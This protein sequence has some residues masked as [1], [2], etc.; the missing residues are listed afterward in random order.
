MAESL[1]NQEEP[2]WFTE[3]TL[4]QLAGIADS[5]PEKFDEHYAKLDIRRKLQLRRYFFQRL[6][7]GSA[8]PA[9]VASRSSDNGDTDTA[10][11]SNDPIAN[12]VKSA[13]IDIAVPGAG[14]RHGAPAWM[15]SVDKE[16]AKPEPKA[17][18]EEPEAPQDDE[19]IAL[20]ASPDLGD[21][22][23]ALDALAAD[24]TEADDPLSAL[25]ALTADEPQAE[26]TSDELSLDALMGGETATKAPAPASKDAMSL[27]DLFAMGDEDTA[28]ATA[29]ASDDGSMSLDD[30]F[31]DDGGVAT[32]TDD[33]EMSLDDLFAASMEEASAPEETPA[34]EKP[35]AVSNYAIPTPVEMSNDEIA[36]ILRP[37]D[38]FNGINDD[39]LHT[40]AGKMDAIQFV[41][42]D[43]LCNEGDIGEVMWVIVEGGIRV[44][45]E[46]KDLGI[47]MPPGKIVGEMSL[48]GGSPRT[49]TLV[50]NG[51]TTLLSYDQNGLTQTFR[52]APD[53]GINFLLNLVKMQQENIR[54]TNAKAVAEAEAK[55]RAEGEIKQAESTQQLAL[56]QGSP[57]F[58]DSEFAITY[59]GARGVSGDY[60]D[61]I[62]LDDPNKLIVIFA[63][64][65][66]HGLNAGLLMLLARSASYT[67]KNIDPNVIDVTKAI[68]NII[69]DVFG[70][71]LFM[72][73]VCMLI[74][75]EACT[76]TYTNAGQQSY[77]YLYRMKTGEFVGLK[78]QTFQ[79][80]I[81]LGADYVSETIE[82]EFGDLLVCYSDGIIE[83]PYFPPGATAVDRTQ[84]FGDV[85]IEALI[86]KMKDSSPQELIDEL[87]RQ[88]REWCQFFDGH[89]TVGGVEQDGDDITNLV[90]RLR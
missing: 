69:C 46:G 1:P 64:S 8:L 85:R 72:T 88:A 44:I 84:E 63:D 33:G 65:T 19:P 74:D 12:L 56:P 73:Y 38:V 25:E 35:T 41:D 45:L 37:Y 48:L 57:N 24:D 58:G 26:E 29:E 43:L 6:K 86:E 17:R 75:R 67:Q 14:K 31:A 18:L 10:P 70:A 32:A 7:A 4:E 39:D 82:Y 40:I 13:G 5:E 90:I 30:L 62:Q 27:D 2:R 80:G 20:D 36:Q 52:D 76:I 81:Q 87:Q 71:T 28:T 51:K 68:N 59:T 54:N 61:F 66:G 15:Q 53:V 21:E 50:A 9:S 89:M 42:K 34:D 83:A 60:Y 77:P 55:A 78:S 11:V 3:S 49:A 23:A 22:L 47:V 79:L 16:A